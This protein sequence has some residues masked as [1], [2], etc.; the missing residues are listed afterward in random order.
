MDVLEAKKDIEF[1]Y[2]SYKNY[3]VVKKFTAEVKETKAILK[4]IVT[5]NSLSPILISSSCKVS[6][7]PFKDI[8]PIDKEERAV[9]L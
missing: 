3:K 8:N 1:L 4:D 5:D 6:I 2:L 7:A 9:K